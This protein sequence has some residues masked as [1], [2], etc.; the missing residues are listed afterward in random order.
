[1]NLF[2]LFYIEFGFRA[3]IRKDI[4]ISYSWVVFC[5]FLVISGVRGLG[6]QYLL[7]FLVFLVVLLM[8]FWFRLFVKTMFIFWVSGRVLLDIVKEL[9][10]RYLRVVLVMVFFFMQDMFRIVVLMFFL[11]WKRFSGNFWRT[12]FEY[13]I[14]FIWVSLFDIFSVFTIWLMNFFISLKF[15]GRIFLDL[16]MRKIRF[17]VELLLLSLQIR[18][19]GEVR[20]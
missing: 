9:S 1:M 20:G 8:Q 18:E 3:L 5:V 7:R 11:V 6:R 17:V 10:M 19:G 4:K 12:E 15:F 2:C 16:S 14:S 13:C